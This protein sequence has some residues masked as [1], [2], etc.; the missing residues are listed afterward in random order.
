MYL[1]VFA[2][3][4]L[5][6]LALSMS[7][8]TAGAQP[9]PVEGS[10][11]SWLPAATPMYAIH[12]QRGPWLFM[13]H[14]NAFLQSLHESD[15]R[16]ADQIGSINWFMGMAQRSAGR[17]RVEFRSMFSAEA[18][19]VG[20]CGYPDL[21]ASG[22]QCDGEKIHDRQHPHDVFMELSAEYDAS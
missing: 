6:V 2:V 20:G 4:V 11:T 8:N 14:E 22:E 1:R 9:P 21:L 7:A 5:C 16:G 13:L 10:G 17:G 12:A 18:A 3:C 15:D 19:T